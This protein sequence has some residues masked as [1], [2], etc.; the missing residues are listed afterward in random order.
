MA[1]SAEHLLWQPHRGTENAAYTR[2]PHERLLSIH[3]KTEYE[4]CHAHH[5]TGV[6]HATVNVSLSGTEAKVWTLIVPEPETDR[7]RQRAEQPQVPHRGA[8][9]KHLAAV[10]DSVERADADVQTVGQ[11]TKSREESQY[12]GA[13][14]TG[15]CRDYPDEQWSHHADDGA[16][17]DDKERI[18]IMSQ[19]CPRDGHG[20]QDDPRDPA[21]SQPRTEDMAGLMNRLHSEP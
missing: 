11:E 17:P 8:M 16:G 10:A 4:Q 20:V 7:R 2:F 18:R 6:S 19:V 9:P 12:K 21:A 15:C 14:E 5:E 3:P 13:P 1:E